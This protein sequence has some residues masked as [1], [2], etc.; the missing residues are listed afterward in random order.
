MAREDAWEEVIFEDE[1][2]APISYMRPIQ[3]S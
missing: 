2:A 1:D 3:V